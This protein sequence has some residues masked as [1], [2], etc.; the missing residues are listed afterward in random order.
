MKIRPHRIRRISPRGLCALLVYAACAAAAIAGPLEL[1]PLVVPAS[2]E[3]H[4]GKWSSPQLDRT[5]RH[6]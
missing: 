3:H 1:P 5:C 6:S 4:V 2:T